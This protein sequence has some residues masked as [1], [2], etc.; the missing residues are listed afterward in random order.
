MKSFLLLHH[1]KL[2]HSLTLAQQWSEQFHA[3]GASSAIVSAWDTPAINQQISQTHL[4]ITLGGDG[5]ILRAARQCAPADIPI[6]GINLGRIGFLSEITPS[7]FDARKIID[8][9]YWIEE[10]MM[11]RSSCTR[12]G[13]SLGTFEALNDV[14]VGRGKLARVIRLATYIDGDYLTTFIA[15][16]AI[17]A[18]ATG[19][20][21]YVFAAGGPILAPEVKTLVLVPIAPYLSQVRSLV[22]PEGSRVLLHLETDHKSIL[23]IDGQIDIELEDGDEI[24]VQAS[25]HIAR[26][27]RMQ[28]RTYFYNTLVYRLRERGIEARHENSKPLTNSTPK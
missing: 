11:L 6:L 19:S 12:N 5:T 27:A 17:V 8:G 3:L 18:T 24:T 16:G 20:T 4:A 1:P 10:R 14:V 7:E 2:P 21:A 28:P 25:P 15:D 9:E 22:L 13:T 26:F 23:T